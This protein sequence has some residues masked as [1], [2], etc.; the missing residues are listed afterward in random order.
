[1]WRFHFL[2]VDIRKTDFLFLNLTSNKDSRRN[3]SNW[4]PP[5][6]SPHALCWASYRTTPL[7]LPKR[8]WTEGFTGHISTVR[9]GGWLRCCRFD[10][11]QK[12]CFQM[13]KCNFDCTPVTA[14]P[15]LCVCVC[16]RVRVCLRE[17]VREIMHAHEWELTFVGAGLI[18]AC[19]FFFSLLFFC[20]C[21]QFHTSRRSTLLP[22]APNPIAKIVKRILN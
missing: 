19:F 16:A 10:L 9:A 15:P 2:F 8:R 3:V 20:M 4:Q 12:T 22:L 6:P 7:H 17:W 14:F 11:F 21:A 1:M 18:G 13:W 5:S